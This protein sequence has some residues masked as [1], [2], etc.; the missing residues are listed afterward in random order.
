MGTAVLGSQSQVVFLEQVFEIDSLG[1]EVGGAIGSISHTFTASTSFNWSGF[2]TLSRQVNC[3]RVKKALILAA[4]DTQGFDLA[5]VAINNQSIELVP[6][7]ASLAAL[8]FGLAMV[9]RRKSR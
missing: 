6:E 7:P 3:I 8:G 1:N 5:A 4:P 2:M 9:L